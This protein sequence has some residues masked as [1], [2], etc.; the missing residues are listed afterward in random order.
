MERHDI[1]S[2]IRDGSIDKNRI[3]AEIGEI[4]GG[5]SVGRTSDKEITLYKSAGVAVQDAIAGNLAL[6]AVRGTNIGTEIDF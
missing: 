3:H 2:L 1:T 5:K 6:A 4:L